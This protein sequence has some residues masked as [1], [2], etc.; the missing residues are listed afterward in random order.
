MPDTFL[1]SLLAS[2]IYGVAC[3]ALLLL[4]YKLF[5]WITPKIDFQKEL[6]ENKNLAVAIVLA[7]LL[8][9]VAHVMSEVIK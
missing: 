6:A 7:A 3:L 1:P 9:G 5:D 8:L 2:I 4:G